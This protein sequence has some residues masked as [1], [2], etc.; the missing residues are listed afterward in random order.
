MTEDLGQHLVLLSDGVLRPHGRPKLP[1]ERRER[2]LHVGAAMNLACLVH[3]IHELNID[4]KF[5]LPK[6]AQ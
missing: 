1:L 2:S 6:A 4:P 5:W 3:E